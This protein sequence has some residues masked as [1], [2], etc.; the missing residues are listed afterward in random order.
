MTTTY[1]IQKPVNRRRFLKICA[2]GAAAL[3]LPGSARAQASLHRW[4]GIALGARAEINLLHDDENTARRLFV[5]IEAEI[6]RLENI[7]SLYRSESELARLNR[8]GQLAVPSLE[9]VELLGLS[10]QLHLVTGGAF[11]PTVQPLWDYYARRAVGAAQAGEFAATRDRTGLEHVSVQADA[12]RFLRPGMAMTLNGIAQGFITDRITALLSANGLTDMVVDLGEIT[13]RGAAPDEVEP[14]QTGWPVTLRPDPHRS[15]AQVKLHLSDAAVASS[16]RL[17][18]TFDQSGTRSHILDPK[19][20][21]P[22]RSG[23]TAAS[24]IARTAALADGLSTAALVCGEERL[25]I[26][27]AGFPATRAFVVRDDGADGWLG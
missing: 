24:V 25:A 4:T 22:V 16:A 7:F 27:M 5:R 23:L 19:S 17:G 9:L 10:Q 11:D 8:N 2:A 18:T 13:A 12:I 20:G 6:E 26:A 1:G 14:G 3:A 21:E 15:D